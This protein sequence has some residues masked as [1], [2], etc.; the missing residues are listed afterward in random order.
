MKRFLILSA[1]VVAALVTA[2]CAQN[3]GV[4]EQTKSKVYV[5]AT[6][7]STINWKLTRVRGFSGEG[8][9]KFS[10]GSFIVDETGVTGG[11]LS[12]DTA[13]LVKNGGNTLAADHFKLDS[14]LN[15]AKYATVTFTIDEIHSVDVRAAT[16]V[17]YE[18][19][20]TLTAAF[21][22]KQITFPIT[23][24]Q[25]GTELVADALVSI[26]RAETAARTELPIEAGKWLGTGKAEV[27]M[28]I[29]ALQK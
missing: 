6:A 7:S 13:S 20:G 29:V 11:A 5:V 19:T 28:H 16:P 8:A 4:V 3:K 10:S 12:L 18:V 22:S 27:R 1:F 17:D 21:W 25:K 9:M 15:A 26:P 14:Y 23:F 2:G 24:V